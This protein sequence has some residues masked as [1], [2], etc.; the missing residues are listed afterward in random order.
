METNLPVGIEILPKELLQII[1][2][3][4][5]HKD[6]YRLLFVNKY[7]NA[8][9]SSELFITHRINLFFSGALT[10]YKSMIQNRIIISG[11]DI[12]ISSREYLKQLILSYSNINIAAMLNYRIVV[13]WLLINISYILQKQIL[14]ENVNKT[15]IALNENGLINFIKHN[16]Y[17]EIIFLQ[18]MGLKFNFQ[19]A[20]YAAIY[21][22]LEILK[23]MEVCGLVITSQILDGAA[24]YGNL[25]IIKYYDLN[26]SILPSRHGINKVIK[27]NHLNVIEYLT[28]KGL[29][30]VGKKR[31]FF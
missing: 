27:N 14:K 5:K 8:T 29:I 15:F 26:K 13:R 6:Y 17:E 11:Q 21:D 20:Y 3:N 24:E 4:L 30:S 31:K 9:L 25:N 12:S 2:D 10:I 16:Y 22:R 1:T 7:L 19:L 28:E 23:Y 18:R